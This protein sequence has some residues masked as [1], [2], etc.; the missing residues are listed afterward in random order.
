M[1]NNFDYWVV[2]EGHSRAG[3]S[4]NWC[5]N[6]GMPQRSTDGTH[7]YLLALSAIHP[8][9]KYFSKGSYWNSKDQQVNKAVE[10]VKMITDKCYLWQV[11]V[12]EQY[13]A[14]DLKIAESYLDNSDL[15]AGAVKFNHFLCKTDSGQQLIAKG[16]W[17]DGSHI[18]VW[19]WSGE[20]FKSHEPPVIEGQTGVVEIPIRYNHYSYTFEQDI[21]FKGKY[22]KGY[23]NLHLYW[24]KL[25]SYKGEF[26]R[27][28][29]DLFGKINK[30]INK[31]ST[32]EIYHEQRT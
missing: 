31:N 30:H 9:L 28:I 23:D 2:V 25:K 11:D 14:P 24:R 12:D 5:R 1:L 13:N 32:I 3:G 7:E 17:G 19:K 4:T 18:R 29:T 21:I 22:Y 20:W 15:K 8:K 26:P 27:P 10:I 16:A 6:L